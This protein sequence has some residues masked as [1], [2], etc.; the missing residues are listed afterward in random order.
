MKHDAGFLVEQHIADAQQ[1]L[2][3]RKVSGTNWDRSAT[4]RY[5]DLAEPDRSLA[6]NCPL[7][8][9]E[10]ADQPENQGRILKVG[11]RVRPVPDIPAIFHIPIRIQ[12]TMVLLCQANYAG[13]CS[14]FF[15]FRFRI[16]QIPVPGTSLL[17]IYICIPTWQTFLFLTNAL[18]NTASSGKLQLRKN[19]RNKNNI[20]TGRSK[21]TYKKKLKEK[22]KLNNNN[23][24]KTIKHTCNR[25]RELENKKLAKGLQWGYTSSKT[26]PLLPKIATET[27]W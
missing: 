2:H 24:I 23:K 4:I 7:T 13:N 16:S 14:G 17:Q 27:T 25:S 12:N 10:P 8:V 5:R 15:A 3:W 22:T 9:S 18:Q 1:N 21:S 11:A 26:R 19:S 6:E 20:N